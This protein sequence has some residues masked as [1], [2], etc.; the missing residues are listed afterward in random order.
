MDKVGTELGIEKRFGGLTPLQKKRFI[1]N[2]SESG[3]TAMV[4]DG[5][6]DAPALVAAD[7]G[8][9]M[10]VHGSAT[11]LAA[12]DV[13]IMMNDLRLISSALALGR[14]T[15]RTVALNIIMALASK[16]VVIGIVFSGVGVQVPEL[17]LAIASD[18]VSSLIVILIGS[19]VGGRI[20]WSRRSD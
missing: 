20:P 3:H 5:V 9:A 13:G 16:A 12:A 18:V 8:I 4:G 2:M 10:G 11:A 14:E 6:N 7:V 1:D 19:A 15:R 17:V